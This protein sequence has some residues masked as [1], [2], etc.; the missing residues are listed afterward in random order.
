MTKWFG[1]VLALSLM[2]GALT[3]VAG[4][5][6]T[7]ESLKDLIGRELPT[8]STKERVMAFVKEHQLGEAD[9]DGWYSTKDNAIYAI[10][11]NLRRS[12][13]GLRTDIQLIFYLDTEGKL[14]SYTVEEVHTWF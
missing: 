8:G 11:R 4:S 10:V 13:F 7:V 2:M 6:V 9:G 5:A 12:L 3:A 14:K 1:V